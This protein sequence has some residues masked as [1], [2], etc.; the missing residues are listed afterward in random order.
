MRNLSKADYHCTTPQT[1][2]FH[3]QK[4]SKILFV[5]TLMFFSC[6]S[7]E[8]LLTKTEWLIGTW[9]SKTS[10]G[11][12]FETWT[13]TNEYSLSAKSYYLNNADTVLFETVE[14]KESGDHLFYIVSAPKEKNEKPVA[15][16]SVEVTDEIIIFENKQ[17]DFPQ[18]ISYKKVANDSL[19]AEISGKIDGTIQSEKFPMKRLK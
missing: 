11:N 14:L 9:E 17:H 7:K 16:K 19:N 3:M 5:S 4:L 12:L 15:F 13:K 8:N 18:V 1:D 2:A 6:S 10:Q